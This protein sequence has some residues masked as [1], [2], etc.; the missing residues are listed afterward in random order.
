LCLV[1]VSGVGRSIRELVVA[2]GGHSRP[3]LG[4]VL[5]GQHNNI[6]TQIG[7]IVLVR[8]ACKNAI[9][10]VEFARQQMLSGKGRIEAAAE[11]ARLRSRP[12]L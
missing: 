9:L 11:A 8:L 6:F 4:F 1:C 3:W 5:R 7:F 2:A 12:S 10:I